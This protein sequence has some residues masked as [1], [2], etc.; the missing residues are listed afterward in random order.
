[1][2]H[3]CCTAIPPS[4]SRLVAPHGRPAKVARLVRPGCWES[5]SLPLRPALCPPLP[6]RASPAS[7]AALHGFESAPAR[8]AV[9]AHAGGALPRALMPTRLGLT[10]SC[11]RRRS[12]RSAPGQWEAPLHSPRIGAELLGFL[13]SDA[14]PRARVRPIARGKPGTWCRVSTGSVSLSHVE[15]LLGAVSAARGPEKME[16]NARARAGVWMGV[17]RDRGSEKKREPPTSWS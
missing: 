2:P 1:M 14:F 11:R 7:P 13:D 6:E 15:P 17:G 16:P 5:R 8:C 12:R 3:P 9:H 4:P 10:A